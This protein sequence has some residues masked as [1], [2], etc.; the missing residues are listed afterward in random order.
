MVLSVLHDLAPPSEWLHPATKRDWVFRGATFH[1]V[2]LL[3]TVPCYSVKPPHLRETS[4]NPCANLNASRSRTTGTPPY[5]HRLP[6]TMKL[7]VLLLTPNKRAS[8]LP[9]NPSDQSFR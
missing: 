2:P 1:P 3:E 8:P 7:I 5:P 9:L 6:L 4:Q